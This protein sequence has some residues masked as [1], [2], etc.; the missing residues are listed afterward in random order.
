MSS[1]VYQPVGVV[2]SPY[3]TPEGTPIQSG[4]A[5]KSPCATIEIFPEYADGLKD[6]DGFS[7]I[8]VL[9]HLHL[10]KSKSLH[11]IPFLDTE[12]HGIF[13]TR[14]PGRPNPI[15][16]SVVCLD[17]VEGNILHIRNLDILDGS[18]V[19][20]VKPYIP[21]FDVFETTQNGWLGKNVHKM[22][23]V[24]DDGRFSKQN[25]E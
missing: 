16:L 17:K 19:L 9:F 14:S 5:E 15:G 13:A 23:N 4:A 7:H 1:I 2:H 22:K 12:T 8:Y 18:P 20:D 6:I 11:V 3:K 25:K 10:A 24:L 21:Q